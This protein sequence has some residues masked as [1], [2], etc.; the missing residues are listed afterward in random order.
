[1]PWL[2]K[3]EGGAVIDT[4]RDHITVHA[5]HVT[6]SLSNVELCDEDLGPLLNYL[7]ELLADR[8]WP[9]YWKYSLDLDFSFNRGV[10]DF[11]VSAH[12]VNFLQRWPDCRRLEMY[13]TSIGD[14]AI[15]ALTP[16]IASG[17]AR[18]V[19]LSDLCGVVTAHAVH[20]LLSEVHWKG[21]YPYRT[22][23]GDRAALWLRLEHN[24]I[25]DPDRLL[26]AAHHEGLWAS[27]LEKHDLSTVRP[28]VPVWKGPHCDMAVHLVLFRWQESKEPMQDDQVNATKQLLSLMQAVGGGRYMADRQWQEPQP[29]STDEHRLWAMEAREDE[30][31]G[32]DQCNRDTFGDDAE[33][34]WSFE[35]NLAANARLEKPLYGRAHSGSLDLGIMYSSTGISREGKRSLVGSGGTKTEI[36][37]EVQAVLA[38]NQVLRRSDF[39]GIVRQHLHAIHSVGGQKRVADAM[40][41]I[42]EA[43]CHRDRA[44]IQK[45]PAFLLKLLKSFAESSGLFKRRTQQK[46]KDMKTAVVAANQTSPRPSGDEEEPEPEDVVGRGPASSS[47]NSGIRSAVQAFPLPVF[48]YQ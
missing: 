6:V 40:Q 39:D 4:W 21:N 38:V 30:E 20:Q 24:G 19:H 10:T 27:V 3:L 32:F 28:G 43:T 12:I 44:S 17:Y 35:E 41:M 11:G 8:I 5:S 16:W 7:S 48:T 37:E 31:C 22:E 46:E 23:H 45:W 42:E 47:R 18:E 26:A 2:K 33:W 1:M 29:W 13:K 9:D 14:R 34:G 36:E 15:A 25:E